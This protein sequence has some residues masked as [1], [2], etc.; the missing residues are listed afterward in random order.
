MYSL[1]VD[2]AVCYWKTG[3][4]IPGLGAVWILSA[5]KLQAELLMKGTDFFLTCSAL[6]LH[7]V[8]ISEENLESAM[9]SALIMIREDIWDT[10]NGLHTPTLEYGETVW[11]EKATSEVS[12][13]EST[14]LVQK[15]GEQLALERR[16]REIHE[17]VLSNVPMKDLRFDL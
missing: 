13:V 4:A 2:E 7:K 6:N 9:L 1:T 10:W 17:R 5:G 16:E 3:P 15:S 11:A 12:E 8:G 14:P